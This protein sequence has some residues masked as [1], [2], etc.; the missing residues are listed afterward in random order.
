MV[1]KIKR[2]GEELN[3]L[4]KQFDNIIAE[5]KD[6]SNVDYNSIF[7]FRIAK[8]NNQH[9]NKMIFECNKKCLFKSISINEGNK[10]KQPNNK[11]VDFDMS[12]LS[13]CY[14]SVI[15]RTNMIN[16]II[17]NINSDMI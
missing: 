2:T 9:S 13:S 15:D 16:E 17:N 8:L 14:G 1:D 11:K 6:F 4:N 10:S 5:A 7:S 12:C 3:K